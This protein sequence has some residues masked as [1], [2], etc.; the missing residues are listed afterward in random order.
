MP[1]FG[2]GRETTMHLEVCVDGVKQRYPVFADTDEG[3][4]VV[5]VIEPA[6]TD[7]YP[8]RVKIKQDGDHRPL[9]ETIWGVVTVIDKRFGM[10]A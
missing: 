3:W 7:E 4:V 8:N 9:T 10:P 6:P 5:Y 1:K 2:F